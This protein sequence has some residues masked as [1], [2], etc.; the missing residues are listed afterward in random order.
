M[1]QMFQ[2]KRAYPQSMNFRGLP[3][4]MKSKIQGQRLLYIRC[5]VY[6]WFQWNLAFL[7]SFSKLGYSPT[8]NRSDSCPDKNVLFLLSWMNRN[9]VQPFA[10]DWYWKSRCS[11]RCTDRT[12]GSAVTLWIHLDQSQTY[13]HDLFLKHKKVTYS[14]LNYRPSTC[15][16]LI[17]PTV[18]VSHGVVLV[19]S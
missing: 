15:R 10:Y 5:P 17:P 8:T 3:W 2:L 7:L 4:V 1:L 12:A 11:L 9:R 18:G 16:F 13:W 6:H 19:F 14:I